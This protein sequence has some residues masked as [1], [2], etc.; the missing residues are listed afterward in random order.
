M[1][2]NSK[3]AAPRLSAAEVDA[4]LEQ[5]LQRNPPRGSDMTAEEAL[6][7]AKAE[8]LVLQR[9][10]SNNGGFRGVI[11]RARTLHTYEAQ[12]RIQNKMRSLGCYATAE[13]AALVFARAARERAAAG[14]AAR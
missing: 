8:G 1:I 3:E 5:Y 4:L 9:S 13:E 6:Q 10:T 12:I 7:R 14:S 11:R 2:G